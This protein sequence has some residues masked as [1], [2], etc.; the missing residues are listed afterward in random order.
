MRI[1]KYINQIRLTLRVLRPAGRR[2]F[3]PSSE[4]RLIRKKPAL[5]VMQNQQFSGSRNPPQYCSKPG[6]SQILHFVRRTSS[7]VLELE[8]VVGQFATAGSGRLKRRPQRGPQAKIGRPP[9]RCYAK[10]YFGGIGGSGDPPQ[11]WTPAPHQKVTSRLAGRRCAQ[12]RPNP[13]RLR[14]GP[15]QPGSG[16]AARRRAAWARRPIRRL[17]APGAGP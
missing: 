11:A 3:F 9:R 4:T 17:P 5:D 8:W 7:E 1:K 16:R 15:W 12:W 2:A 13:D 6:W 10:F 14:R